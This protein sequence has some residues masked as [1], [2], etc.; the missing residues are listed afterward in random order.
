[1]RS[2]PER[3]AGG[4]PDAGRVETQ[5]PSRHQRPAPGARR[6]ERRCRGHRRSGPL[7]RA[8]NH[9]GLRR[10]EGR[11]RRETRVAQRARGPPDGG[12]GAAQPAHRAGGHPD[13]QPAGR[14]A[15]HRVYPFRQDRARPD[16]QG[17][18][19]AAPGLYRAQAR[20][21]RSAGPGLR[22]LD[23]SRAAAAVQRKPFPLHV[24]LELELR[25]GGHR[26][27]RRAPVGRGPLGAR[28]GRA[29]ARERRRRAS[30]SS[31]TTSR[32]RTP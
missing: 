4:H 10:G 23:R 28:G 16:G 24:A 17:L 2:G 8:R 9:P 5:A 3:A 15:R 27:R 30:S 13:A 11:L 26:Q 21:A 14:P 19:R 22:H 20:P 31:T 6:Q 1:M 12:G 7:A 32:R 18:G 25:D 29:R